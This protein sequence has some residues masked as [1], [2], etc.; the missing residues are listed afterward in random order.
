M[1]SSSA[2]A[3]RHQIDVRCPNTDADFVPP[4]S[5]RDAR[6][7]SA[8]WNLTLWKAAT[9]AHSALARRRDRAFERIGDR[10]SADFS[11]GRHRAGA[12]ACLSDERS[13]NGWASRRQAVAASGTDRHRACRRWGQA[14]RP[15]RSITTSASALAQN[16]FSPSRQRSPSCIA[17][18]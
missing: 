15:R 7:A 5:R 2:A 8:R 18:V 12:R 4:V 1:I 16:H 17:V 9:N 6:A 14:L 10:H 13:D 11:P 3:P